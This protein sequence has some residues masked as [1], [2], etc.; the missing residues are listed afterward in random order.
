MD[1][2]GKFHWFSAAR[3][4]PPLRRRF[5]PRT[6]RKPGL[7]SLQ[8]GRPGSDFWKNLS[9]EGKRMR[10][11]F[12]ADL[13]DEPRWGTSVTGRLRLRLRGWMLLGR[14]A[15]NVERS[16]GPRLSG[17]RDLVPHHSE[18]RSLAPAVPLGRGMGLRPSGKAS[19]TPAGTL[20]RGG[21]GR[22]RL[23]APG[24]AFIERS[25]ASPRVTPVVGRSRWG[26]SQWIPRSSSP[27]PSRIRVDPATRLGTSRR[28]SAQSQV[29]LLLVHRD[30][31]RLAIGVGTRKG[32]SGCIR[33]HEERFAVLF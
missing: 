24:D 18:S 19:E 22:D 11:E 17:T 4:Q 3:S 16:Q 12:I 14:G 25:G 15:R 30:A 9:T 32:G 28:Q 2:V 23:H 6:W 33:I 8:A 21:R 29:P 7:L 27:N 31:G 26:F 10:P 5:S 13:L 20:Q 1:F